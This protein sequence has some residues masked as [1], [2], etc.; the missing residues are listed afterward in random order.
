MKK[1]C[2]LF[3]CLSAYTVSFAQQDIDKVIT[4]DGRLRQY[5]IHLPT[6]YAI[7]RKLPVI[8]AFHGGGGDYKRVVAL[9]N[10]NGLADQNNFIIV[11]PNAV[12]KAWNM[13]GISSRVK[14]IDTT[15]DDVHFISILIDTLIAHYKANSKRIYCT[16]ISRGGM[17]SLYLAY[18]LS[19]RI[20]GIAPVCASIS[21]TVAEDYSFTH[22]I[23]TL[24]IN[25]TADPLVNYNGGIGKYNKTNQENIDANMLP[26]EE[27]V[28]KIAQLNYCNNIPDTINLPNVDIN[29]GCTA[30]ES[31]YTCQGAMVDF[32]KVINGGHTWPGG[33]Q[34][35]PKLFIGRTCKDFKAEEKII[36]FFT[37]IKE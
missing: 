11:Y 8:F 13:P 16:G 15:V 22:P 14:G 32:I 27:L 37:A 33:I 5:S 26:T 28:E 10:F 19:D 25:G 3:C 7:T 17:F 18:K 31:L 1:I 12:N 20:D 23:P 21:Q 35:L 36:S 29:D 30:M 9:Y 2:F 24:L 34:Y 4:V 6:N